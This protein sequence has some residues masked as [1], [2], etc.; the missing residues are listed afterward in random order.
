MG[1]YYGS[2]IY[3]IKIVLE[4]EDSCKELYRIMYE[5]EMSME[6]KMDVK[7]K[8]LELFEQNKN[9]T[10]Y[11]YVEYTTTYDYP[12]ST[13]KTWILIQECNL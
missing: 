1:I 13:D 9:I 5:K 3:G 11:V 2:E 6:Q 12:P 8:Y 10:V 4:D 7:Q